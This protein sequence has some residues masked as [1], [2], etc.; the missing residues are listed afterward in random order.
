MPNIT[1]ADRSP[2][3][4]PVRGDYVDEGQFFAWPLCIPHE[5][6]PIP[7]DSSF[8]T[9]LAAAGDGR[10]VWGATGG[11]RCHLF[12]G[13]FKGAAGGIVDLCELPGVIEIPALLAP[14]GRDANGCLAACTTQDGT[15]LMRI[16]FPVPRDVIQEPSFSGADP[17][18]IARWDG[19]HVLGMASFA[20]GAM[21]LTTAGLLRVNVEQ[22]SVEL[23]AETCSPKPVR[24]PVVLGAGLHWLRE[25]MAL[26]TLAAQ[27]DLA[28]PIPISDAGSD[29]CLAARNAHELIVV[30]P[31]GTFLRVDPSAGNAAEIAC[32]PLPG[33]QCLAPLRDGRIYGVCGDG[34]GHFF[35]V[36]AESA[37]SEALGAIATAVGTHRY[38]FTFSCCCVSAEGTIYLGEHDRGGHLWAYYPPLR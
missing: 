7:A 11:Q 17:E 19:G 34:I 16:S 33:V 18:L 31:D 12:A 13:C 10:V 36:D 22:G 9:A 2:T 6:D 32:A 3:R 29:S 24:G 28:A 5:C 26:A 4:P 37:A 14:Q 21:V 25:D 27:G 20:D 30:R 23:V 1:M 15:A 8:I 38:G 35:R